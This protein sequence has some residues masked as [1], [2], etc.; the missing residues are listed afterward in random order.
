MDDEKY[1]L[2]PINLIRNDKKQIIIII[3]INKLLD[4]SL[5]SGCCR[6]LIRTLCVLKW[7]KEHDFPSVTE[8]AEAHP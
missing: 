7:F 8:T 3:I 2:F 1:N 6:S 5:G 4:N